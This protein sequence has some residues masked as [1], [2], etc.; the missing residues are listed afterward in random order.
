MPSVEEIVEEMRCNPRDI[1]FAELVRVCNR[2]FGKPRQH[3]SHVNY[4]VEGIGDPR[5]CI[6]NKDGRAKPY[7]VK[8]VLAAIEEKEGRCH[9]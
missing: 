6:Q 5:I 4:R 1:R 7:Q 3:G 2:Y 9:V 8:Q